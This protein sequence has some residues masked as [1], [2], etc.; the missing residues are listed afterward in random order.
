MELAAVAQPTPQELALSGRWTARGI[1]EIERKLDAVLTPAGTELIADGSQVQALDT[2]GAWVLQKMLMR[3]RK[4]G[5]NVTVRGLQPRFSKL[6]DV[7]AEQVAEQTSSP[8][9]APVK[10]PGAQV[11]PMPRR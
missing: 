2:A 5:S 1:G 10:P 11:R 6:L 8:A 9:P 3:L 4:E 7:V